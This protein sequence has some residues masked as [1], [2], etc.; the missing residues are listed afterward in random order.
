MVIRRFAHGPSLIR[1]P[2]WL[3]DLSTGHG[4]GDLVGCAETY[5]VSKGS[6]RQVAVEPPI[7]KSV[8][9]SLA[10][11]LAVITGSCDS[12]L[13]TRPVSLSGAAIIECPTRREE[14]GLSN[15]RLFSL[16]TA[17]SPSM[18][19][20]G[21]S[22]HARAVRCTPC[23]IFACSHATEPDTPPKISHFVG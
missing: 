10:R 2:G 1:I 15:M 9:D 8:L 12:K 21:A 16:F 20:Q 7:I 17:N 6:N 23:E 5:R 19:H 18:K 14:K 22:S 13:L 3:E 4:C 11:Q